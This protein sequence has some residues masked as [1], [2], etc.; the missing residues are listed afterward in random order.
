[1]GG[2][3]PSSINYLALNVHIHVFLVEILDCIYG[4]IFN[5][6]SDK[7]AYCVNC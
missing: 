6:F 4:E 7:L 2:I 5:I 3:N 1:M